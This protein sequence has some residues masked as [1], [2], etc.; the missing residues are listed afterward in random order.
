MQTKLGENSSFGLYLELWSKTN[1]RT[2]IL[3]ANDSQA[4]TKVG[5]EYSGIIMP[6]IKDKI[7]D[8]LADPPWF[9]HEAIVSMS[10]YT[11]GGM[12]IVCTLKDPD[13]IKI[14]N[15]ESS[16]R[17]SS[18]SETSES[19]PYYALL[20]HISMRNTEQGV[21]FPPADLWAV[22]GHNIQWGSDSH[23][24]RILNLKITWELKEGEMTSFTRYNIYFESGTSPSYL[25][26]ARVRAF[27]VSDLRVPNG[28]T[29]K[30]IIQARGLDGTCQKLGESPSLEFAVEA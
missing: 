2:S 28:A 29:V 22:Q 20:G 21:M 9:V 12:Y 25:G 18:F 24:N 11:L 7:S 10:G 13:L 15:S 19:S 5:L 6:Q 17:E 1:G 23:G 27:Y 3:L 14:Q 16:S 26:F 8:V 4:F 30:F